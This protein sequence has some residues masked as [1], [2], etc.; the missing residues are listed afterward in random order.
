[1][2]GWDLGGG[3]GWMNGFGWM[4]CEWLAGWPDEGREGRTDRHTDRQTDR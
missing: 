1:M 2:D 3:G 4:V